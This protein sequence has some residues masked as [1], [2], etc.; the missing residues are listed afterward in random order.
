MSR[1]RHHR[2]LHVIG[3]V[4]HH[5]CHVGAERFFAADG[6]HRHGQPGGA[7]DAVVG[8]VVFGDGG[9]LGEGGAHGAGLG[10]Q[11]GVVA[12]GGFVDFSG[13]GG[14]FVSEAVEVDA[15]AAGHQ[16]LGVLAAEIEVPQLWAEDD[17]VP[18][19]DAGHRSVHHHQAVD[20]GRVGTEEPRVRSEN[21]SRGQTMSAKKGRD[22]NEMVTWSNIAYVP[23]P[24]YWHFRRI[25]MHPPL[26]AIRSAKYVLLCLALTQS[27]H[28]VDQ[29]PLLTAA[30]PVA[31]D[32]G[33]A[34]KDTLAGIDSNRNA[35]RD[36]LE[37]Y[38]L[39]EFGD[40]A[41]TLRAVT[42]MVISLRA[43]M[44]STSGT[45]S[46]R[47]HSMFIRS[48]ECYRARSDKSPGDDEKLKRLI[49]MLV[50]TPERTTAMVAHQER[51]S[52]MVFAV[53]NAPE[54][55][56]YCELQADLVNN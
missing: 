54:W 5:D 46:S 29:K 42:N 10:V 22:L 39:T 15:L 21:P 56:E 34:G 28:A 44:I 45:A 36:D 18:R 16:A 27:A 24:Y 51:I 11:S 7:G 1:P 8:D 32:P 2:F 55:D 3:G 13:G 25:R 33:D 20:A 23:L 35:V 4:A 9:E 6:Q 30:V 48:A 12:A 31:S 41:K 38:I 17:L 19:G 26:N 52:E 49:E 37:K 14:E 40:R 47:A 50:N 53:R 43:G